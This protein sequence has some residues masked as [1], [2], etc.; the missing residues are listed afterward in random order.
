M[1]SACNAQCP[2]EPG[3]AEPCPAPHAASTPF[4]RCPGWPCLLIGDTSLPD[5]PWGQRTEEMR[6][7]SSSFPS[8]PI[9]R[10]ALGGQRTEEMRGNSSSFP[11]L[12]ISIMGKLSVHLRPWYELIFSQVTMENL[13]LANR[14]SPH[15]PFLSWDT[16]QVLS[17]PFPP[18]GK[19]LPV[20]P[21]RLSSA[22]IPIWCTPWPASTASAWSLQETLFATL[23]LLTLSL[24]VTTGME[25]P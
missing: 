20:S 16:W 19:P 4:L 5:V 25:R 22:P 6:G 11:S 21:G 14:K 9:S 3:E 10:W 24:E 1:C 2:W 7:N 12:P 15:P 8:L 18:H 17:C 23:W 13:R